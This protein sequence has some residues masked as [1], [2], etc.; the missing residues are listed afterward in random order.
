MP[1]GMTVK[2]HNIPGYR[3]EGAGRLITIKNRVVKRLSENAH[4]RRYLHPSS[5]RRTLVYASFLR[6]SEALHLDIFHQPLRTRFFD[7]L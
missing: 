6:I 5:L 2:V 4:L 3:S 7:S 1:Q